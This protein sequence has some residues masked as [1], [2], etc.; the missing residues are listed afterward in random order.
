MPRKPCALNA[1]RVK[2]RMSE[3][4]LCP[5]DVAAACDVT[6]RSV[7]NWFAGR[8]LDTA[9][10]EAIARLLGL[11][12]E[13]VAHELPESVQILAADAVTD[14]DSVGRRLH[15]SVVLTTAARYWKHFRKYVQHVSVKHWPLRGFVEVFSNVGDG[16]RYVEIRLKPT[17][18][19]AAGEPLRYVFSH[20]V[21]PLRVDY[22]DVTVVDAQAR[23]RMY[24]CTHTDRAP[25]APD[26]TVRVWT[27]F[28]AEPCE[29]FVRS[30]VAFTLEWSPAASDA[31]ASPP[32]DVL[33]FP[34]SPHHEL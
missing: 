9:C 33:C 34:P 23:L 13:E 25:L 17:R 32:A 31:E 18:T 7:Q 4:G 15:E 28:D 30:D 12:L 3:R 27:W 29:F 19:T 8:P 21:G 22:G 20:T 24:L 26:G 11:G 5:F 10:V 14:L 6:E 2:Q 16:R 1:E